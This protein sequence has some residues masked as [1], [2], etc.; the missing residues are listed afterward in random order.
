MLRIAFRNLFR[1]KRRNILL[2][3][4]IA[5]GTMLLIVAHSFSHGISNT[6]I[7]E[8]VA[9]VAGH[10]NVGFAHE[11]QLMSQVL[12]GG[13][14]WKEKIEKIPGVKKVEPTMGIM[15]RIIGN[16]KSDNAFLVAL[17]MHQNFTAEES[18]KTQ[19]SFP[20]VKGSWDALKDSS[21]EN[22]LILSEAKAK[23]LNADL[24]DIL[25]VRMQ[26]FS[27]Q[28]QA[29]RLTVVGIFQPS[30]MFMETAMFIEYRDMSRLMGLRKEDSPYLYLTIDDPAKNAVRIA[31]EIWEIM[32]PSIA[33]L[34]TDQGVFVPFKGES[35]AKAKVA[36]LL[37]MDTTALHRKAVLVNATYAQSK[38]WTIGDTIRS[39][40][41]MRYPDSIRSSNRYK[42]IITGMFE[43]GNG[44]PVDAVLV[45]EAS[46]YS[47]YYDALPKSNAP[48]FKAPWSD[49]LGTEWDRLP[50]ACSTEDL[51]N[52]RR[53]ISSGKHKAT[54][55]TVDSMYESASSVLQLEN[56]LQLIT[57]SAVLV[58]FFI[59]L[60]GVVNTLRMTVRERTREIGT[61]RAIGMQQ[62]DVRKV[63]LYE[64]GLLAFF[65]AC[66]GTILA[67]AL[68]GLLSSLTIPS[69]GNPLGMI[70]VNN[71]LV[72]APTVISIISFMILIISL[73]LATAF[74]PAQR[75]ARL[76]A[77]TALRH[78][79]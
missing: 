13:A 1:Q 31:D 44:L 41:A 28:F 77:A 68:M 42:A 3:S 36:S 2:G 18:L 8:V 65:S 51:Q 46:F 6:L 70:L 69:A 60:I 43:S 54:T 56:A 47:T 75:A 33:A 49:V 39:E 61:L 24:G 79:E 5:I 50:R 67:F 37:K 27:G 9:Y 66:V 58:I 17:N 35:L 25:R 78:Y 22:P 52:V 7:N 53:E 32:K 76:P 4:A 45:H 55:L 21:I 19:S 11:G 38:G 30:N 14:H 63:F 20:M 73:A 16:G 74:F 57:A 62:S 15:G 12:R 23:Y 64:T 59:I 26:D 72:F 40:Y 29:A 48:A 34:P 71:H 10:A